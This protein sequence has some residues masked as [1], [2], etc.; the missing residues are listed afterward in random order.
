MLA[1]A[2]QCIAKQCELEH[3]GSPNLNFL[4]HKLVFASRIYTVAPFIAR[5][6]IEEAV[7]QEKQFISNQ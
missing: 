7:V 5:A 4:K 2:R 6:F 3:D 1:A